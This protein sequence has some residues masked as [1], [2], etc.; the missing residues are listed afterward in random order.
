MNN[1]SPDNWIT[2]LKNSGL[3]GILLFV[4]ILLMGNSLQV[5]GQDP[6]FSQFYANP[7]YLNPAFTGTS[8]LPRVV[9]NYRNQW[10]RQ[11]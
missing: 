4:L 2:Y 10:P 5:K 6:E 7:I 9:V 1:S 11:G 8:A 3:S